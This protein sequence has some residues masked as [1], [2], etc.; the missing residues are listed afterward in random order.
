[1]NNGHYMCEEVKDL[2]QRV[3]RLEERDAYLMRAVD[4]MAVQLDKVL[5]SFHRIKVIVI[6]ILASQ[7]LGEVGLDNLARAASWLG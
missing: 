6:L 7:I 5:A 3:P 1:M 4:A 2:M